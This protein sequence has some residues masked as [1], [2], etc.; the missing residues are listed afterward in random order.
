[1]PSIRYIN[2]SAPF[3]DF[4]ASL[5]QQGVPNP[6][7]N[8]FTPGEDAEE[9]NYGWGP[10]GRGFPFR[11]QPHPPHHG[12]HGHHGHGRGAPQPPP[13]EGSSDDE[14]AAP[15]YDE[16]DGSPEKGEPSSAAPREGSTEGRR[17][18]CGPRGKHGHGH[19]H[20][21]CGGKRGGHGFGGRGGPGGHRGGP[22]GHRGPPW[23]RGGFPFGGRGF[24]GFGSFADFFNSE[25]RESG[26]ESFKPEADVFDTES[27]YVLHL[28]L[29]GAK[30]EDL[31]VSWDSEKSELTVAGVV[32][33]PGDEAFLQTLAMDERK[34]GAFERKIRL[35]SLANP[36]NVAVDEI[37]AKLEDGILRVEVPKLDK[38]YVEVK[39]VDVE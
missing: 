9:Q 13:P 6:M 26:E 19:G 14:T 12:R 18:R 20:G 23:A 11:P 16:K 8:S 17:G 25:P 24:G 22:D 32:H 27:S 3:W 10:W 28:S 1:M 21:P 39:M 4:I 7:N 2:Q 37:T 36:A 31:G 30:K 38:D 33:R 29:P 5:E 35:G 34:V 15:P